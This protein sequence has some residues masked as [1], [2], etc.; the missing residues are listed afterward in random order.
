MTLSDMAR[1]ARGVLVRRANKLVRGVDIDS[2]SVRE[3]S[4]FVP[5]PGERTDGHRFIP[6]ALARGASAVLIG[7]HYWRGNEG[8][9]REVLARADAA[10]V[11]VENTLAA[12]QDLAR[13]HLDRFPGLFRIGV[14]GSSGKTTT[15][16]I[17]G[18]V[19]SR[20]AP[21][22][23]SEG[24]L[25][26]EIGVPLAAFAVNAAHRYAVF[27]MGINHPGEMDILRSIVRPNLAVITNIGTAHI[28]LLGSR[29]NIA[30]EKIKIAS[31]LKKGEAL[32]VSEDEHFLDI[33]SRGTTGRLVRYGPR[34]TQGYKGSCD[35]GLD[36]SAIDWEGLQI[37]F[38]LVGQ[39]NVKN[40][41][42]ALA[43]AAFLRV[44]APLVKAGLEAVRPLFGRSQ[45]RRGQRTVIED[46]YNANPESMEQSLQFLKDVSWSGGKWAVLGSMRELGGAAGE[47]HRSLGRFVAGL[48]LDGVLFFG[49]EAEEAWK[50]YEEASS[51]RHGRA[52]SGWYAEFDELVSR[53]LAVVPAGGLVLVKGSRSLELERLVPPLLGDETR[54]E[55]A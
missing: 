2:R 22:M 49:P 51:R 5:L 46:C 55:G 28:G 39:Y 40:A 30:G 9:L 16:E 7:F 11:V 24:N 23:V 53:A 47:L 50:G 48:G 27:E 35:L 31:R 4:L 41:L 44:P 6:E 3:S 42:C 12:L 19:L 36:G 8:M 14:T 34:H 25:N 1:A 38:P 17:I 29:E 10:G 26:S 33:L 21:V 20:Y 45:V 15:K 32:F 13:F 37:R 52:Q 43:V 18:A 54:G